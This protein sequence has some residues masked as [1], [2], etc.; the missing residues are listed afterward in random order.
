MLLIKNQRKLPVLYT[1]CLN[2]HVLKFSFLPGVI[3]IFCYCR[4][5]RSS[6]SDLLSQNESPQQNP[7]HDVASV[8]SQSNVSCTSL[9]FK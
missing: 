8:E 1:T 6:I 2:V 4:I 9:I 5:V 7:K 3:N